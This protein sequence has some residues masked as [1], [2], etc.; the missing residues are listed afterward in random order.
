MKLPDNC[1]S[2]FETLKIPN[3]F[4]LKQWAIFDWFDY[5]HFQYARWCGL[6]LRP[7]MKTQSKDIHLW[8][9]N[10]NSITLQ[11]DVTVF[12]K[13]ISPIFLC[14]HKLYSINSCP[15][16]QHFHGELQ[17]KSSM[18]KTFSLTLTYVQDEWIC[19]LL[20]LVHWTIWKDN[21]S[22]KNL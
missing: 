21:I 16:P 20:D 6:S 15:P 3:P 2:N 17:H 14:D 10:A 18:Y 22:I 9:G 12:F 4:F 5:K 13:R 19:G 11:E 1:H 8:N 7:E